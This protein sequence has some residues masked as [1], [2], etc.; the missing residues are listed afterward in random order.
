LIRLNVELNFS[1]HCG[2]D[3]EKYRIKETD[4]EKLKNEYE[5]LV[6]GLR[7]VAQSREAN[8]VLGNPGA[9]TS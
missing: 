9:I 3:L 2:L 4:A 1:R 7:A 8:E 6:E 5:S